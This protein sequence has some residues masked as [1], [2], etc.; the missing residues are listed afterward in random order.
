M[1]K[2][3]FLLPASFAQQRLWFIDSLMPGSALYNV[4]AVM[5]LVGA[6]DVR[7]LKKSLNEI[8]Q[9]HEVLRTTFVSVDEQ[10]MQLIAPFLD[11]PLPVA[12]LQQ[13]DK[14]A[15]DAEVVRLAA[16]ESQRPF[17]LSHGPLLRA[18]LLRL[19]ERE[20]VLFLTMHHI[21]SD[22]W[23]MGVLYRELEQLYRA[24]SAR[25]ASPLPELPIQYAD[26]ASWQRQWLQGPT[27]ENQLE[28]WKAQ[29]NGAPPL[30]ELAADRARPALQSFKGA[31]QTRILPNRLG[32]ALKTVS[33]REGAT[34]FMALFAAFKVLLSR[35][36]RREDIV[37][38]SP[39][40]GRTRAETEDLI[41]FFVNT[42]VLRSDLSGN[43]GF[44]ELLHRVRETALSAYAHQ[45][46]PFEKLVEELNPERSMSHSPLFQVMF[47]LH[48]T[49]SR[50]LRLPGITVSELEFEHKSAKFDLS[51]AVVESVDELR[52]DADFSTELFDVETI[53]RL[54]GH[55][56][57]LLEGIV[58]DPD[59]R[60]SDLPLLTQPERQQLL[61]D[62]N[63]TGTDYPRHSTV[64]D[65]F[66]TQVE[67]TP[68]A[69]ALVFQNKELTY[70]ELNRRANQLAH[71]LISLGVG[72]EVLVG[73]CVERSLEMVVALLGILKAGGAYLPLD[74]SYPEE[75]LAF[76]LD[77]GNVT[78][79][80][81]QEKLEA[82]LP[83]YRAK[84]IILECLAADPQHCPDTNPEPK[85]NPDHLAYVIYTSG[86]TGTPKAVMVP[87]RG[88]VRLVKDTDYADFDAAQTFLQF[89]PISF[90][91]ST[92][93]IWGALLNGARLVVFPPHT[94]SLDE[95]ADALTHDKITTLWLTASL[96]HLMVDHHLERL[97]GL[98]QLLAG[99]DVLSVSH[100][101]KFLPAAS[102][103]R[104]INGYGPTENTTFTC[105]HT[106]TP[107][108]IVSSVPI[109]RPIANTQ[110]YILDP[111]LNPVPIGVPG[112]LHIGGAG[113]ARG[114]LSR[115]ELTQEKFIPNPFSEERGARLYKTGD[116]VRYLADGNIEFLGRIDH[117]VKIR[118]FRIEPGEIEA[119]LN[120]HAQVNACAVIAREDTPRD[121]RLVA[122]VVAAEENAPGDARLRD[123]LKQTLPDYMLPSAFVVLDKLPLTPNG[124]LDRKSLPAPECR[125]EAS[126]VAPRTP[127]QETLAAI[128]AEVL[129]LDKIG[130]HDNFF[131]LGGHSLLATQVISR[132]RASLKVELPLRSLF[133]RPTVAELAAVIAHT[134]MENI[135]EEEIANLLNEVEAP[136]L[137]RSGD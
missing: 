27:L 26:Y 136:L 85:V 20:H 125:A 33:R 59:Q 34:L 89:A 50:E 65:L 58:A 37:I 129:K 133:E 69:I 46:L 17:D 25:L 62:W 112:E 35:Y 3:A 16:E 137:V 122:Y 86:S 103:C 98:R 77:D 116:L 72:P 12:T 7:A 43:P 114:Y 51:V 130:I 91:A 56:R 80:I 106:V 123:H 64:S 61:I 28:Y 52:L 74:P 128:W 115:H 54:L 6:L 118:G 63:D 41:G 47:V 135:S 67:K 113:L 57:T 117:Q 104:L 94:P 18:S 68:D 87:H 4:P 44:R 53:A 40:A 90:D 105:C 84:L 76:M 73:V 75:R 92:F 120:R 71:H 24:Y 70:A 15:S 42:L 108:S 55:Y 101:R 121:K 109:G 38:G 119:V 127:T 36:T 11:L 99:G 124:K 95:L 1:E 97:T 102:G 8:A 45:D 66:E 110:V 81:T 31:R 21:V 132:I 48:N 79:L 134:L 10:P 126:Y 100:V 23:S 32:A 60:L 131:E 13:K 96:F 88:V 49:G 78:V 83:R 107:Q 93:E 29:L 2:D 111:Q 5:R 9:R 22:G 39:I 14:A 30:L 19:A 82:S